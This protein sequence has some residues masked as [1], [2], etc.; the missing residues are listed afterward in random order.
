[1]SENKT[2]F[3][4]S[5]RAPKTPRE[6]ALSSPLSFIRNFASL[7]NR[8]SPQSPRTLKLLNVSHKLIIS[9]IFNN[10]NH[11]L[12]NLL[13]QFFQFFHNFTYY[14]IILPVYSRLKVVICFDYFIIK[15][16]REVCYKLIWGLVIIQ[17]SN[18]TTVRPY[19]KDGFY[20]TNILYL[21]KVLIFAK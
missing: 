1:M 6:S 8:G 16:N 5:P 21:A 3:W 14:Y 10:Y 2:G 7:S 19:L 11:W 13:Y 4:G 12:S 20:L 18:L 9:L 15:L 17:S